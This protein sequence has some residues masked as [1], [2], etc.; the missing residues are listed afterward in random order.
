MRPLTSVRPRWRRAL[1]IPLVIAASLVA[2]FGP[3][4]SAQAQMQEIEPVRL[5]CESHV[6][7]FLCD[8]I[9]SPYTVYDT[10]RWRVNL[11]VLNTQST[12]IFHSCTPGQWV[13]V[14]VALTNEET[15]NVN[16]DIMSFVCRCGGH[17]PL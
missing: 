10:V 3:A 15:G 9:I 14:S 12:S 4:A 16:S 6:A 1:A 7:S 13:V 8:A 11:H 2:I 5:H 17:P